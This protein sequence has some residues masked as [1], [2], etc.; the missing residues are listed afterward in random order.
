MNS[1]KIDKLVA[2]SYKGENFDQKKVNK[3]VSL[4]SRS[5]LK[6]YINGLK[7]AE[8]RRS[9]VISSP[10]NDLNLGEFRKLFPHKKIVL[11]KDPSLMLG[12]K[13]IDNDTVYEFTLKNSLDKI[14]S[15]LEQN[16]D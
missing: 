4:I 14:I 7:L 1:K 9:L 6:K 2:E 16:Y 8:R 10:T 13:V 15:Y 5:D 12:V 3:I 11:K